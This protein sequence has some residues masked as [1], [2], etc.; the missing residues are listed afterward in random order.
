[1]HVVITDLLTGRC[2]LTG[3]DNVE[4]LKVHLDD[5]LPEV[6]CR[7]AEFTKL[8]RL[9]KRQDGGSKFPDKK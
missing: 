4:C 5:D 6:L 3:K 9:L 2:E 7:P 8:L 1:M